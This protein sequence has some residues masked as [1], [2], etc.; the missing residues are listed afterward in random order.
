MDP[1]STVAVLASGL[2]AVDNTI[3]LIHRIT[4]VNDPKAIHIEQPLVAQKWKTKNWLSDWGIA[5]TDELTDDMKRR[6]TPEKAEIVNSAM[7]DIKE[8]TQRIDNMYSKF[9]PNV[10]SPP[11]NPRDFAKR[12]KF[13]DTVEDLR[14]LIKALKALNSTLY[15][16]APPAPRY[17][18]VVGAGN[19]ILRSADESVGDPSLEEILGL[20]DRPEREDQQ[21]RIPHFGDDTRVRTS[22]GLAR[23]PFV[24][25]D[26]PKNTVFTLYKKCMAGI[27]LIAEE[28]GQKSTWEKTSMRHKI[29]ASGLFMQPAPL[30]ELLDNVIDGE[31]VNEEIRAV[32]IGHCFTRK[33]VSSLI[34]EGDRQESLRRV[35]NEVTATL[36]ADDK[37][38]Q[39][40]LERPTSD[41]DG[42]EI[43]IPNLDN[44]KSPY[45]DRIAIEVSKAVE[46]LFDLLPAIRALRRQRLFEVEHER[47]ANVTQVASQ[48]SSLQERTPRAAARIAPT[49]ES[50]DYGRGNLIKRPDVSSTY[51]ADYLLDKTLNEAVRAEERMKL[52]EKERAVNGE[53]TIEAY[54]RIMKKERERLEEWRNA[55]K[56]KD[57]KAWGQQ[58][59]KRVQDI[60]MEQSSKLT[61]AKPD[62][63]SSEK[64]VLGFREG[65]AEFWQLLNMSRRYTN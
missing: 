42:P 25:F 34:F 1:L 30:D 11:R 29:W 22:I 10:K 49:E 18:E 62:T 56:K 9:L 44:P 24:P 20:R 63:D 41:F 50:T 54:S 6:I 39:I 52:D 28:S 64:V 51:R 61:N 36:G 27:K 15:E 33:L 59:L 13:L 57:P 5:E 12:L 55:S 45:G 3:K 7:S 35:N 60:L 14:L 58:D 40:A 38:W 23:T 4:I 8:I 47:K 17:H 48:K 43:P 37:V 16:V 21:D 31:L 19:T 26:G 46:C 32:I 65:N 53:T 2:L